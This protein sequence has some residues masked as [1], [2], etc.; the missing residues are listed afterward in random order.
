MF[1]STSAC[2]ESLAQRDSDV[3][4]TV[5]LVAV[6]LKILGLSHISQE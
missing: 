5:I 2:W 1:V 6:A 4:V 3:V